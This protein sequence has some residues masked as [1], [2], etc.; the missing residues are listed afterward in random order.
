[1]KDVDLTV[2]FPDD[3]IIVLDY[4]EWEPHMPMAVHWTRC[5]PRKSVTIDNLGMIIKGCEEAN[6][7]NY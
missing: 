4:P 7:W 6:D 2:I 5:K 1:M 3:D